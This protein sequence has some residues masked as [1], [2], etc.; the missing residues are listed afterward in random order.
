MKSTERMLSSDE[1]AMITG[2]EKELETYAARRSELLARAR[3]KFVLIKGERVVDLFDTEDEAL[4]RGYH[5]F[6]PEAFL[7]RQ[8]VDVDVVE[9]Y[10]SIAVPK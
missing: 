4:A 10:T 7:V 8:I 1:A 2:L 3:G 9:T 5:E 6:V